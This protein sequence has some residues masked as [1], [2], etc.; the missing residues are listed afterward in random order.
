MEA[1]LH[2]TRDA[3][4]NYV[5][6][7]MRLIFQQSAAPLPARPLDLQRP[8]LQADRKVLR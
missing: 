1:G 3:W 4:L 2:D 5:G 8:T 6:A 7:D